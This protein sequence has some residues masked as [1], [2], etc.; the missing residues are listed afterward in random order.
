MTM[1]SHHMWPILSLRLYYSKS[2]VL[3]INVRTMEC[4][5]ETS[6]HLWTIFR[7]VATTVPTAYPI[8]SRFLIKLWSDA[9]MALAALLET[10]RDAMLI[11][12]TV[13]NGFTEKEE[14]VKCYQVNL[15]LSVS[16]QSLGN[17]KIK[18]MVHFVKFPRQTVK[19]RCFAEPC[20]YM[21]AW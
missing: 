2:A 3:K 20:K 9:L 18:T 8:P 1:A 4:P 21:P 14:W 16:N 17:T 13:Y 15:D 5:L 6:A 10:T 12:L 11:P 19:L 7:A